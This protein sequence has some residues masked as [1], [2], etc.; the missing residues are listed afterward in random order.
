MQ[1]HGTQK[2]IHLPGI[3]HVLQA[4]CLMLLQCLLVPFTNW[5]MAKEEQW[6]L[7]VRVQGFLNKLA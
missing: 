1:P 7:G 2:T 4:C 6:G 5:N 3:V